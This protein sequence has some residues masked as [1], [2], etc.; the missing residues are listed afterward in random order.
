MSK[1]NERRGLM[2]DNRDADN[3]D[4]GAVEKVHLTC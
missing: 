3:R 2:G 1:V 4:A